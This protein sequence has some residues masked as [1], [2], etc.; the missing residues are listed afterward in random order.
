MT[1]LIQLVSPIIDYASTQSALLVRWWP[2]H[3]SGT[4]TLYYYESANATELAATVKAN[5]STDIDASAGGDIDVVVTPSK[6]TATNYLHVL[7]T[8]DGEDSSVIS[9]PLQ[10]H[11]RT[12]IR[13]AMTTLLHVDVDLPAVFSER[14]QVFQG[15][16]FP[17]ITV[18][19]TLD[20]TNYDEAE[21][22]GGSCA[23]RHALTVVV[24]GYV[25]TPTQNVAQELDQLA[26]DIEVSIYSQP[27][28]YG[29]AEAIEI[30]SQTLVIDAENDQPVGIITI[31]F[32]VF[33]RAREG[34]PTV[35]Y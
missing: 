27:T 6:F 26:A 33:Y 11:L 35:V 29:L 12:Q 10:S 4:R 21:M 24:E 7:V 15:D 34:A 22:G 9:V 25:K 28:L 14:E 5:G 8:L 31:Q 1:V 3:S 19:A 17:A 16:D 23:P 30:E 2:A 13:N 32:I 20:E 18:R